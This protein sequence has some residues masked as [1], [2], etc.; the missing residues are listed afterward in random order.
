MAMLSFIEKSLCLYMEFEK[1][2]TMCNIM[3]RFKEFFFVLIAEMF[4]RPNVRV[5][6]KII[7][8]NGLE[9]VSK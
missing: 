7:K 9:Q 1:G 4:K 6:P 8:S 3:D 5:I 2:S